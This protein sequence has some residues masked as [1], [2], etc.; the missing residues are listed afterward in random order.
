MSTLDHL[1]VVAPD[2]TSGADWVES[3]L[4]VRPGGGGQHIHMGTHNHVMRTGD[5]SYLE[6][7]AIDPTADAPSRARWFGMDAPSREPA[8]ATWV[9]RSA[10][11]GATLAAAS[12]DLGIAEPMSRGDLTWTVSVRA[13]GSMALDGA[14]PPIIQWDAAIPPTRMAD[15]GVHLVSLTILHP[16]P[17]R[18]RALLSSIGLVGPITVQPDFGVSLVASFDTP[19]GP[20]TLGGSLG[21]TTDRQVAVDLFNLTWAYLD[22]ANPSAELADATIAAA[23]ASLWHW[24]RIGTP[25]EWAIGEWMCSRVQATLGNGDVALA[26]AQRCLELCEANRV[27]EFVPASAQEALARAYAVLGDM[28]AARAHR[29]AAYRIAVD[30]DEDDRVIIEQDLSTLPI[31]ET[32]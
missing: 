10:D 18:V 30:L 4:G 1:V 11:C 3:S 26:H 31:Q 17:D 16:E 28:T 21:M 32:M 15:S 14:G 19:L 27:E 23:E 9:V 5:G 6:V 24:R 13:D 22:Q 12:E 7:I 8:L 20:R 2:L 29:N 25:N